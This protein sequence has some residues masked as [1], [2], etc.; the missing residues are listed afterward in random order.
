[1]KKILF[2]LTAVLVSTGLYAQNK[3]FKSV[4]DVAYGDGRCSLVE[5]SLSVLKEDAPATLV[6]E[7]PD[8]VRMGFFK[9]RQ[10]DLNFEDHGSYA[11]WL[12]EKTD[13]EK[14][15]WNDVL[16]NTLAQSKKK[17]TKANGYKIHID[18]NAPKYEMKIVFDRLNPSSFGA[19]MAVGVAG[20]AAF[21][22]NFIVTN[23]ETGEVALNL[24]LDYVYGDP[25]FGF[26][27]NSRLICTVANVFFGRYLPAVMKKN[28]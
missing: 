17:F 28:K 14:K 19:I 10:Y 21:G 4:R 27:A 11:E 2:I 7:L 15:E 23:I 16:N 5:G 6:F 8:D 26:S 13:S 1:M 18:E 25:E 9:D 3:P 24:R 22:G 20:G 12:A